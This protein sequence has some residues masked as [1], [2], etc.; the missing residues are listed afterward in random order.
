MDIDTLFDGELELGSNTVTVPYGSSLNRNLFVAVTGN[1]S[2]NSTDLPSSG[3]GDLSVSTNLSGRTLNISVVST[4]VMPEK[5][6]ATVT[7]VY[8]RG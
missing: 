2:A 6:Y 7:R 4:G 3:W 1:A 5:L 8:A